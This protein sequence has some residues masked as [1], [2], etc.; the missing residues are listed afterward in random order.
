MH[1]NMFLIRPAGDVMER[2]FQ[3]LP[4]AMGF[5]EFL[6]MPAGE[7]T[8][9]HIVV[10]EGERIVGTLR[11]N[12]SL[13]HGLEGAYTGVSLGSVANE[14][15]TVVREDEIMFDVIQQF[16]HEKASMIVVVHNG[17][18][19]GASDVVGILTKEHIADSVA[20]SVRPYVSMSSA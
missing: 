11:V 4:S 12:T 6:R 3:V 13:R 8:L 16:W 10:S 15:F 20:E 9:R 2:D 1:A 5:D 19:A 17:G 14:T 18:A 7:G